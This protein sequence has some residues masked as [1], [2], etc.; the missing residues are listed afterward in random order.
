MSANV[1]SI[2]RFLRIVLGIALILIPLIGGLA[3]FDDATVRIVAIV[4]GAVLV[5]TALTSRC[6]LYSILGIRTCR[7]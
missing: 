6:P 7:N 3:V 2:D 4:A 5:V 1:G